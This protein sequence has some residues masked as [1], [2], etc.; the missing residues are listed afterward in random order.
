M[1]IKINDL[2]NKIN[3]IDIRL[4]IFCL[5]F[6]NTFSLALN[7]N[8][9]EYFA[10]AKAF[11]NH[12]WIPG[13]LSIR[14]L[15]GG[16]IIF[17]S[18][19]GWLLGFA[20]FEQVAVF[21]R[22]L[23]AILFAFPL[24]RIFKKVNLSNLEG[25]FILQVI[26]T[27]T[28]Q[29]F[30][31]KEWIFGAF[32]AKAI[33]Y[34]FVFYSLS[35]LLDSRYFLSVLFSCFAVYLHILVGGWYS[36]IL[37]AHLLISGTRPGKVLAY[38]LAFAAI[39]APLG[40]YLATRYL[41]DNPEIVNGIQVSQVYV[42]FRNH[43][44][45]DIIGQLHQWGSTA[46]AGV[47]LSIISCILCFRLY[48]GRRTPVIRRLSLLNILLFGQQFLSLLIALF[49]KKGLFLQYYPYRTSALSLFLMLIIVLILFKESGMSGPFRPAIKPGQARPSAGPSMTVALF[50]AGCIALG[51][52]VK[53]Y[54]NIGA[55]R[56]V[57]LPGKE[58]LA[59]NALYEWI[60]QNTPQDAVVLDL[61]KEV[62]HHLDF[63]RK[64]ER[65]SFSVYKFVPTTN[66]LI[67]DWY[68][69]VQEEKRVEDNFSYIHKLKKNYRVDFVLSQ[70][71]LTDTG[72]QLAY[73]NNYY[74]LYSF[75]P[76]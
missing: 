25:L 64:T 34:V 2:V 36:I 27:L 51:L 42:Y 60:R 17:E 29:S 32:E 16:R 74:S 75:L 30:I 7:E 33:S 23:C 50:L 28:H 67:Y 22:T 56:E 24:A 40:Y 8:E 14:D 68:V 11:M 61:D 72:L 53:V 48:S 54:K 58:T 9:E 12:D 3:R 69:R 70:W 18:V 15:P 44:H 37:F 59:R 46:Q 20:S 73:Q 1:K 31:G 4:L 49:D 41:L 47:V 13:A 76:E 38:G 6:L 62:R 43:H 39:T 26:C 35:Y 63:V 21:G 55:S 19:I 10:F 71:P 5:I 52:C 65:D 66:R 45:L 57:I